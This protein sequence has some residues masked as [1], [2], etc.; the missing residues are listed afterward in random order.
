MTPGFSAIRS[1]VIESGLA[2]WDIPEDAWL[3]EGLAFAS[4]DDHFGVL[5]GPVDGSGDVLYVT[6]GILQD[7]ES[8]RTAILDLCNTMTSNNPAF[9]IFL[10]D[11]SIGWDILLQGFFPVQLL[12]DVPRF[13]MSYLRE[14]PT[15][16]ENARAQCVEAV[17][18]ERF[19]WNETDL[20]RLIKVASM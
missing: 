18:G 17:N 9:P 16:A 5:S 15:V 8:N 20:V 1:L 12:L 6:V 2:Y 13:F 19:R 3:A 7:V 4:D 11:A 10:H 14:A